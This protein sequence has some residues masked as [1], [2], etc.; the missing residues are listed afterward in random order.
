MDKNFVLKVILFSIV[1]SA[2]KLSAV[3]SI[4]N[5]ADLLANT[6]KVL[7][8]SI[9]RSGRLTAMGCWNKG[10]SPSALFIFCENSFEN[11]H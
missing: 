3:R 5:D 10:M 9:G 8:H 7:L 2:V 11:F 1:F 4:E 6:V